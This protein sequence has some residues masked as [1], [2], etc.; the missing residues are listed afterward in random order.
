MKK[1][2][3]TKLVQS[4]LVVS[5]VAAVALS[6]LIALLRAQAF[7]TVLAITDLLDGILIVMLMWVFVYVNSLIVQTTW[8]VLVANE[9]RHPAWIRV[10][11]Q[12]AMLVLSLCLGIMIE[13]SEHPVPLVEI[14]E[15]GTFL[16][17]SIFV[18]AIL[19]ILAAFFLYF[20]VHYWKYRNF[21]FFDN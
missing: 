8:Q 14:L 21:E 13:K 1:P 15:I 11:T 7:P 6:T 3:F 17:L 10:S 18:G 12:T 5:Y 20:L 19:L 4:R 2:D 16:E 9:K